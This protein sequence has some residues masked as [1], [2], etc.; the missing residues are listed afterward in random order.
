MKIG[1][2]VMAYGT[3][4]T[5]E[6]VE[7]YYTRIRHGRAPT[8]ELLADLVRRY[9]AIGGTS[10]LAER[11]AA[12][13]DALRAELERVAPGTFDVR[14]GSKYEPPLLEETAASFRDDGFTTVVG[15]VL[16]PHSS[17]MSTVQYMA[18]AKQALGEDVTL[19]EINEWYDAAG[20][21]E[22][23]ASRVLDALGLVASDEL[24]STEVLF[25]AHSLPE[26]ILANGDTYPEQLKDSAERAAR[27]AGVSAWD[28]AWQSAG[29][30]ADPWI[31]PDILQVLREK[32]ARGVTTIV[33]CPIGFVADHLEV[34]FD[35]DIEAQ[36]VADEIGLTL[37]RTASLNDDAAF[38]SILANVVRASVA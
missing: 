29:R 26:K 3:P 7:A 33:S 16:A 32:R 11:T 13:V 5:P 28:V 14:F 10:P 34:L 24:A 4:S 30:T 37:I 38:V 8:P 9:N 23:I 36:G 12:Q 21:L 1:V 20:F 35:I 17:S 2:L 19:I 22:L 27:L 25:S 6:D 15:L 31:G 18:R